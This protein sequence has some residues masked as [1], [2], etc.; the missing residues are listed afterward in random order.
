[1]FRSQELPTLALKHTYP[2]TQP[3]DD[4]SQSKCFIS[5]SY[6]SSSHFEAAAGDILGLYQRITGKPYDFDTSVSQ[7]V[8]M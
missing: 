7:P 2:H 5:T 4:G 8:T 1:M 3:K 6:D